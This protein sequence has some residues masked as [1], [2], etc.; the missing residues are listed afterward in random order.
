MREIRNE[1]HQ[2][3]KFSHLAKFFIEKYLVIVYVDKVLTLLNP[4]HAY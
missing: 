4:S 3:S 2:V 1:I